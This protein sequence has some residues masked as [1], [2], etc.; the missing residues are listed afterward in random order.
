MKAERFTMVTETHYKRCFTLPLLKCVLV[1]EGDYI[2]QKIYE[3]IC[4]SHS[5]ERVLAHKAVGAGFYWPNMSKDSM[6]VV[7]NGDKC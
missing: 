3:G 4:G 2:F 7:R 5:G 6:V 1:N